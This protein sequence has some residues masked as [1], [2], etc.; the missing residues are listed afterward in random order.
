[1]S[2]IIIEELSDDQ[3]DWINQ[4]YAEIDFRSSTRDE[5]LI[6]ATLEGVPCG[7]G[8]LTFYG[9]EDCEMGGIYVFPEFQGKGVARVVVQYL[10]DHYPE[11]MKRMWCL[12][13]EKLNSFYGSFGFKEN[14]DESIIP[15]EVQ[16]K[17][18]FC[19]ETYDE[20]VSLLVKAI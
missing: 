20:S 5:F 10:C 13:F 7:I 3:L 8:R 1:M 18:R 2:S 6:K 19:E 12:P 17:V 16:K 11:G 9:P 15:L 4:K 14:E